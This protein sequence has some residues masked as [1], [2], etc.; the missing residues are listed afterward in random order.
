MIK[1]HPHGCLRGWGV[2]G[3]F[4]QGLFA[5]SAMIM[6]TGFNCI[7]CM[8]KDP[9]TSRLQIVYVLSL[10]T[11]DGA[12]Y[13]CKTESLIGIHNSTGDGW[14]LIMHFIGIVS[15]LTQSDQSDCSIRGGYFSYTPPRR[16][17]FFAWGLDLL[18]ILGPWPYGGSMQV[19]RAYFNMN[20]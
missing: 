13:Y 15:W 12:S 17:I 16:C 9:F 14:G 3:G 6:C 2:G 19:S 20:L 1:P 10:T 5:V 8:Q 4:G 11:C 18:R 7:P